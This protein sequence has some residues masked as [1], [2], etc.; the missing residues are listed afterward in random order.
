MKKN[1]KIKVSLPERIFQCVN[2]VLLLI[3]AVVC[4][5]PMWHVLMASFSKPNKII[6]HQGALIK[7]LGFSIQAYKQVLS[8]PNILSGYKN[9][10]IILVSGVIV[11]LF[12][13]SLGAYVL[14]RKNLMW[15]KPITIFIMI[16]MFISGGLIPF[17]LN[18]K[19]LHLTNTLA[20]IVVPFMINTY[21][22]IILRTAFESIP[23]S[24][25]DAA[26][27]DGASHLKILTSIVLPLSKPTLSVMVL[28]YGVE[29]WNGW[30]WA[31]AI[32]RDRNLL[33]LQVIL[34]EILLSSTQS[35]Q[36]GGI[37]GDTEAI[38]MTIRYATII[39]ATVPILLVYP[40]IQK[41]F[42]KGVMIGAVKE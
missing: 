40:F 21:N 1:K 5:Y 2:Y 42:T 17:Y 24:L 29:K 3:L 20:G 27:I 31:S 9:T 30:F 41:Y 8:N 14:S 15:K 19:S 28:Y 34:R 25:I 39:V 13:T 33:P 26:E 36:A 22:M 37:G 12:M 7:P 16:T 23:D 4:I 11:C 32:L 35:M 38:G 10:L 6:R 18:L